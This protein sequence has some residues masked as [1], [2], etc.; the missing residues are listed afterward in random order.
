[1]GNTS[2][3]THILKFPEVS[4]GYDCVTAVPHEQLSN[5]EPYPRP[6]SCYEGNSALQQRGAEPVAVALQAIVIV[7][8][9]CHV[10]ER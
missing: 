5:P 6:S 1:M 3:N 10:V 9:L 2:R 4:A 8:F 7:P